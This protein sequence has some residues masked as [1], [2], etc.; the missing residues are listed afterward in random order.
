M[1]LD[2]IINNDYKDL[3]IPEVNNKKGKI[4]D[5]IYSYYYNYAVQDDSYLL[6]NNILLSSFL[7]KFKRYYNFYDLSNKKI[8]TGVVINK[9]TNL[10]FYPRWIHKNK[11]IG[12]TSL[13]DLKEINKDI[14]NTIIKTKTD[15]EY[16]DEDS[17]VLIFHE[18]NK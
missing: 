8:R 4:N 10:P 3:S 5:N 12:L 18:F 2:S 9:K 14:Y 17:K 1:D 15:K 6:S 13:M 16:L 11:L 7:F